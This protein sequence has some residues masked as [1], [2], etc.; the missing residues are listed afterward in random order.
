VLLCRAACAPAPSV[1]VPGGDPTRGRQAID[2][3]GCGACHDIPGIPGARGA[4]GPPLSS[5]S[6]RTIVAGRLAN[7]PDNLTRWIQEPQA[8][9]P[10][11]AMPNMG[12]SNA[13]TRDI[14][15]YLYTLR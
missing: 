14:A 6:K 13:D 1:D 3:Y 9:E 7:T 10:G 4:V 15:A 5:F 11:N 12:V 8:V 2:R